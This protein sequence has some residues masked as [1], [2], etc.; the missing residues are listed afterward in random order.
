MLD[1]IHV[2]SDSR[3][4]TVSSRSYKHSPWSCDPVF[5][6]VC[7]PITW[8]GIPRHQLFVCAHHFPYDSLS[9]AT[10]LWK[11][12]SGICFLH[13]K[14]IWL[15]IPT[16][17][18]SQRTAEDM[19]LLAYNRALKLCRP[20]R[21]S[22]CSKP[23][24]IFNFLLLLWLNV[25]MCI[26]YVCLLMLNTL[27]LSLCICFLNFKFTGDSYFFSLQLL[28]NFCVVLDEKNC[29]VNDGNG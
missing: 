28:G 17:F 12:P 26:A 13:C 29:S 10:Y 2:T 18:C 23:L 24:R 9:S 19:A 1:F 27:L 3:M 21:S 11:Y 4:V 16:Q 14:F 25:R 20:G 6:N 22:L 7:N 15:Q 5:Q 8:E